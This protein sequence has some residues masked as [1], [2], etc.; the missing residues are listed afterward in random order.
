MGGGGESENNKEYNT[1]GETEGSGVCVCVREA[2]SSVT[3]DADG[4]QA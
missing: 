3:M 1:D 4:R 2:G